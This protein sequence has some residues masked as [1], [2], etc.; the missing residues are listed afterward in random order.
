MPHKSKKPADLDEIHFVTTVPVK[1]VVK[2]GGVVPDIKRWFVDRVIVLDEEVVD[3]DLK[4][5]TAETPDGW[6][7]TMDELRPAFDAVQTGE[8]PAW[9]FGT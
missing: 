2:Y 4:H 9:E 6:P 3:L 7:V 5:I 8:S 1:I